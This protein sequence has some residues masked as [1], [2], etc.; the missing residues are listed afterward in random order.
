MIKYVFY[1]YNKKNY[2]DSKL[3]YKVFSICISRQS[4]KI[5]FLINDTLR[6][7]HVINNSLRLIVTKRSHMCLMNITFIKYTDRI[8]YNLI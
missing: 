5:I 4:Y 6:T 2:F 1:F 8:F 7:F 3:N